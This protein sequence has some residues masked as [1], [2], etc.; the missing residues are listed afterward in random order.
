MKKLISAIVG[1]AVLGLMVMILLNNKAKSDAKAKRSQVSLALP[2]S[3]VKA[4]RQEF[5]Q[6]LSIVGT[7]I[8]SNDVMVA[9]ETQ[10][11]IV[12]LP[13]EIGD[14][15]PAG[16]VIAVV[17]DELKRA[18]VVTAQVNLDKANDDLKRYD[19]L[20]KDRAISEQQ[21]ESARLAVRAAEAQLTTAQRLLRDTKITA[22]ISGVVTTRPVNVGTTIQ[23][24]TV[25][26]NIVDINNLK[27]R[28][29]VAERDVFH[30][31]VGDRVD[32]TSDVYP[33]VTF[34]GRVLNV[35][36]KGDEAHTYPVEIALQN[37][38]AHPLKAGMFARLSFT[39]VPQS[40]VLMIPRAAVIGSVKDAQVYVVQNGRAHLRS[41]VVGAESGTMIQVLKG[42]DEGEQVVTDGQNNVTDN[43]PV[44]I[45]K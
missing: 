23:N 15:K 44:T 11:R 18:N 12:S 39:T 30:L 45:V 33:G 26:A 24:G 7:V 21:I 10:G 29:N 5:E 42:I 13:T 4:E 32:V 34:G 14:Y 27:V 3:V 20:F 41:I 17:D 1:A 16:A 31:H 37:N 25:I 22:P 36:V 19:E 28:V 9:S 2:V 8:A 40:D 35:S 6:N 43:V 38:G